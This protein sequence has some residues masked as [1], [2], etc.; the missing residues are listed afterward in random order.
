MLRGVNY[1]AKSAERPPG[2][3]LWW[4]YLVSH[5]LVGFVLIETHSQR[6]SCPSASRVAGVGTSSVYQAAIYR[7]T[8]PAPADASQQAVYYGSKTL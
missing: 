4:K 8:T 7:L 2:R 5:P 6:L 1:V 3:V